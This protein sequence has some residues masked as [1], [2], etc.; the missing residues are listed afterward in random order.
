[1]FK[2]RSIKKGEKRQRSFVEK[3][4]D[5]NDNENLGVIPL[6]DTDSA[7]S[8]DK[9]DVKDL[10]EAESENTNDI[11]KENKIFKLDF[12]TEERLDKNKDL[13]IQ[14]K[15]RK[16]L[17]SKDKDGDKIYKG[18]ISKKSSKDEIV[19]VTSSHIRQNYLMDYQRDVCKDFLKNGYCGFGDTCK[20][21]HVRDEFAKVKSSTD[22]K[23][24]EKAAKRRKKF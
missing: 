10:K 11:A 2:K 20:F 4:E 23:D 8:N 6:I 14:L 13:E 12:E 5:E 16:Q 15:T 19:K 24:W 21:L 9:D 22:I 3:S 18:Q 17:Q 1:M 7:T